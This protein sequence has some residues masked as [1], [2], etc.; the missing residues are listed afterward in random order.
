VKDKDGKCILETGGG[1][2]PAT[3]GISLV[4]L[5]AGALLVAGSLVARRIVR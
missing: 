4:T 1:T 3:G 2:L 5:G